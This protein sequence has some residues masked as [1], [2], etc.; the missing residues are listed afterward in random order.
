MKIQSGDRPYHGE[1]RSIKR[2][3]VQQVIDL[4][5][6]GLPYREIAGLVGISAHSVGRICQKYG[7]AGYRGRSGTA[8]TS[9]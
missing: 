3:Q 5:A 6:D 9:R 1:F 4:R 7:I 2:T 8:S